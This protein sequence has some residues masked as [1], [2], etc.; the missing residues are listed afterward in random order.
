MRSLAVV[1]AIVAAVSA[2]IWFAFQP[3][4]SGTVA[5]WLIA[6]GPTTAIAVGATVWAR[7]VGELREWVV[8]RWGDFSRGALA[9]AVL[10]ASAW[11][12]ARIVCATGSPR[13]V[14]LVSLYAQLGDPRALQAHAGAVAAGVIVVS[15]SEEIVWRGLVPWLLAERVG[16]RT[17]WVY[18]AALY[19]VAHAP[20]L[21][22]LRADGGALNPVLPLAALGAGLVFGG[23][24][25]RVGRLAPAI[26]AHALF[27]W[28]AI[29]MFPLWG[30]RA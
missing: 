8:P 4:R 29:M 18:S 20:A 15:A 3:E 25:R 23:L 24:A 19:A 27:D 10:F 16:S 30:V 26:I 22:A 2:A 9:A 17:A 7:H 14:W 6:G 13:E 5:F 11:G 12:F 1:A 28:C 21:W